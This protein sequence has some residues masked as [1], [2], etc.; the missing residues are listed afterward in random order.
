METVI[1]S[2]KEVT[3]TLRNMLRV[4]YSDKS[5]LLIEEAGNGTGG[6]CTNFVDAIAFGCYPSR[7]YEIHGHE[8]KATRSDWL[9]ELESPGKAD[10]VA[11]YCDF[12][13]IVSIDGVVKQS[14]LPP[15]WGLLIQSG[16]KFKKAR[17]A[18]RLEAMPLDRSIVASLI[19]KHGQTIERARN[20]HYISHGE[21]RYRCG[22]E[23]GQRIRE[24]RSGEAPTETILKQ[25]D[26]FEKA[27]GLSLSRW[28]GIRDFDLL[29]FKEFCAR[30]RLILDCEREI[31]SLRRDVEM[32]I[33]KLDRLTQ[34]TGKG[35]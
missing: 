33:P 20:E 7:G 34:P 16:H 32:L 2:A 6:N 5:W 8:I 4:R 27:T 12:W 9:K 22:L 10:S 21:Y 1:E 19:R 18:E 11:R 25:V 23:D 26:E 29:A 3:A 30:K 31:S 13:W 24:R 28:N 35:S 14:E 17:T 15:K